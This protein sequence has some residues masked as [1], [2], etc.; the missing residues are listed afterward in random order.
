LGAEGRLR[1]RRERGQPANERGEVELPQAALLHVEDGD[2]TAAAEFVR[3]GNEAHRARCARG[4]DEGSDVFSLWLFHALASSGR[5]RGIHPFA[6]PYFSPFERSGPRLARKGKA[7]RI[8]ANEPHHPEG[9][10]L[11][12][13][14]VASICVPINLSIRF[15]VRNFLK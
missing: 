9:V 14:F 8:A 10:A 6:S 11:R 4:F 2:K 5:P 15:V 12:A 1:A 13:F 7:S 3:R